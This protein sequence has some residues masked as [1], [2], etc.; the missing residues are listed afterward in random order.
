[1]RPPAS[2]LVVDAA[3]LV[4]AAYGRSSGAILTVAQ[5]RRL[6]TTDRVV[7]ESQRRIVLGLKRPELLR[8]LRG[9]AG[10]MTIAQ[11]SKLAPF[12]P[13]AEV[14]LR[15]GPASRNGLTDDAH[16]LALAWVVEGD[17]WG[18]DRDFAGTGVANWSTA[19]LLRALFQH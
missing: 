16:I 4:A 3:I 14:T 15:N 17:I 2:T 10:Q 7:Q 8:P 12:M 13:A 11:V 19:N 6:V 9:F 5:V 1:M 18:T